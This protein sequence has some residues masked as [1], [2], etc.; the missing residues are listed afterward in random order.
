P[1]AAVDG[2]HG[3][4]DVA[5]ERRG[6]ED[7]QV[8]RVFRLAV[9]AER[10][11]LALFLRAPLGTVVAP[12]LLAVDAPGRDRVHGDAVAADLARQALRPG[13]HRRLGGEGAVQAFG[14]RLA[15]DVD[16]AAPL[17]RDHLRQ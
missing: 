8:R 12:D 13:M 1:H 5:R 4:G 11:V 2:D 15:G 3:A 7:D 10:N 17:A 16:D 14:L 6:E 9:F